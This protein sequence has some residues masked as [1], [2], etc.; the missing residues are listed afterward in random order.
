MRLH[1]RV[2]TYRNARVLTVYKVCT[3]WGA[4]DA[5]VVGDVRLADVQHA[6]YTA[7]IDVCLCVNRSIHMDDAVIIM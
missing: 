2:S 3:S 4:G 1:P 5:R 7:V 6:G